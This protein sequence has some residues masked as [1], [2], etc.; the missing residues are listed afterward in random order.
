MW[1]IRFLCF[2]GV[3]FGFVFF[4]EGGSRFRFFRRSYEDV[5]VLGEE[6]SLF[7]L[8]FMEGCR[9]LVRIKEYFFR[10]FI[11]CV[12]LAIV[13]KVSVLVNVLGYYFVD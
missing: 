8:L 10:E 12:F 2:I 1:V 3:I 4:L 5:R 7:C 13:L 9:V 11:V 6:S